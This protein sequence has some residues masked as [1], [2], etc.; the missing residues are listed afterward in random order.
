MTIGLTDE[1][2]VVFNGD[3]NVKKYPDRHCQ[4]WNPPTVDY[5]VEIRRRKKKLKQIH[6]STH[7]P[8]YSGC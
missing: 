8:H 4:K 3:Y 5:I 6:K 1:N 7:L 2:G